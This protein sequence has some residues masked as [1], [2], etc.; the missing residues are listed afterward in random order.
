VKRRPG[1]SIAV[2]GDRDDPDHVSPSD[3]SPP[4]GRSNAA[5]WGASRRTAKVSEAVAR[6]LLEYV[7]H[8]K[9]TPGTKLPSESAMLEWFD[10]GRDSLREALRILEVYGL[11]SIR[12][13]PGGGPV[14]EDVGP[15]QLAR[16]LMFH[17]NV[18][19][20]SYADLQ[21]SSRLLQAAM[22]G[23][24]ASR[25]DPEQIAAMRAALTRAASTDDASEYGAAVHAFHNALFAAPGGELLGLFRH[26][27]HQIVVLR[28]RRQ[29]SINEAREEFG[30]HEGILRAIQ[31]GR[32]DEATRLTASHLEHVDAMYEKTLPGFLSETIAWS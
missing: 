4:P 14:V 1:N 29:I 12:P 30:E 18:K 11:L 3:D 19:G 9:P 22:A 24:A 6:E 8:E 28:V 32:T 25:K 5:V 27:L 15:Q 16:L 20:I 13:G 10:V 17:L 26:A 21:R 2:V 7:L 31:A 23:Q